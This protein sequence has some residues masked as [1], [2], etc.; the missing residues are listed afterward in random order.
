MKR[1]DIYL[2]N[3]SKNQRNYPLIETLE[4]SVKIAINVFSLSIYR[5]AFP[6]LLIYRVE[7][8]FVVHLDNT[9]KS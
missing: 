6:T 3:D 2:V 7:S 4:D 9:V 8:E 5:G 1:F